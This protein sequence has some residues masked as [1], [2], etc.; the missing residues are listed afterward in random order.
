MVKVGLANLAADSAVDSGCTESSVRKEFFNI[1]P[2]DWAVKNALG[3]AADDRP[4]IGGYALNYST[5]EDDY[6]LASSS[7]EDNGG[8]LSSLASY[9]DSDDNAS[10]YSDSSTSSISDQDRA[11][12]AALAAQSAP[13]TRE[14]FDGEVHDMYVAERR[15][16]HFLD[17]F[18]NYF[19]Y[20]TFCKSIADASKVLNPKEI[21]AL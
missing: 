11:A 6:A 7:D 8:D 13:L 17:T 14:L 18:T 15:D 16:P 1:P 3:P 21:E 19:R 5:D 12:R 2:P 20:L 9:E 10:D 4:K